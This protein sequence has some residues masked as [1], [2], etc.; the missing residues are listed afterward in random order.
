MKKTKVTLTI[1]ALLSTIAAAFAFKHSRTSG[2]MYHY[3]TN[4]GD[5]LI[6]TWTTPGYLYKTP[7]IGALYVYIDTDGDWECESTGFL[8]ADWD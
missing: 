4:P 1:I 6:C 3:D 7:R 5:G 2:A 8:I